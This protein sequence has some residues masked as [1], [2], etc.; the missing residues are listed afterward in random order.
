MANLVF[1]RRQF[2]ALGSSALVIASPELGR[3]G[4]NAIAVV[5]GAHSAQRTLSLDELRRIFLN[6]DTNGD[7]GDRFV[8]I[9]QRSGSPDRTRFDAQV[10]SMTP[11]EVARY[12]IDQRLRG[13]RAPA[14][15]GSLPMLKRALN[16][17]SGAISYMAVADVDSSLRMLNIDGRNPSDGSY[18]IR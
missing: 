6:K 18:P 10:L 15:V 1:G 8:P 2:L 7:S 16:E 14:A 12:W 13:K 9:N 4:S 11:E 3:A 5:V 17:L